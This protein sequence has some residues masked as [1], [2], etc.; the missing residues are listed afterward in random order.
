MYQI[1][2]IKKVTQVK[3]ELSANIAAQEIFF[4]VF[5][6]TQNFGANCQLIEFV[7]I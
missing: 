4:Q 6:K 5:A 2:T 7:Y 3:I 1:M